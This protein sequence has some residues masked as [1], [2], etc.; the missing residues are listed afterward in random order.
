MIVIWAEALDRVVSVITDEPVDVG[1]GT[2]VDHEIVAGAAEQQVGTASGME[3]VVARTAEQGIAAVIAVQRVV[4][5]SAF[6]PVVAGPAGQAV[7]ADTAEQG[8]VPGTAVERVGAVVAFQPIVGVVAGDD[9]VQ[10]VA[11]TEEGRA[12]QRQV[13]DVGAQR[14]I[15]R[16]DDRIGAAA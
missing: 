10:V 4:T 16:T 14:V 6:Q 11:L 9:V 8:V 12:G 13:L 2:I 1:T 15:G 5:V 3:N 7:V